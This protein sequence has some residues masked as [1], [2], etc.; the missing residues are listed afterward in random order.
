M[1]KANQKN[2]KYTY[3]PKILDALVTKYGMTKVYI[4]MCL[5]GDNKSLTADKVQADYK[6]LKN[7]FSEA[8]EKFNNKN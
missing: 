3:D 2:K 6:S 8:L 1:N 5:K 7:Q 4:R